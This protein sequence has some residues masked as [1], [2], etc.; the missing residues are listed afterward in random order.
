MN[1]IEKLWQAKEVA[2]PTY[3]AK[4][5]ANDSTLYFVDVPGAKQSIIVGGTLTFPGA[6]EDYNNLIYA[7]D[8]LGGGSSARL[9]Q[10]L[11]IQKGYTYGA[12]AGVS[13]R[14]A[15][16]NYYVQ[17][18]VRANVT[19]ESL[20]LLNQEIEKYQSTFTADDLKT[21]KNIVQKRQTRQFETLGS[22]LGVLTSISKYDSPLD[23]L[24]KN[25][26]ELATLELED[27][28]ATIDQYINPDK[29]TYLIVGDAKTQLDG[30]ES[31]GFGKPI[32]LD[33]HGNVQVQ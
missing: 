8:R 23:Y 20:E 15:M 24:A 19:K 14:E 17:T 25:Q 6:D 30:L 9:F 21:T 31:L 5:I 18:S 32:L 3:Q 4:T 11:R 13:R 16:S 28:K 7:N 27:F 12:Y 10:L 22:L 26:S 33:I 29:M 1:S 2:L